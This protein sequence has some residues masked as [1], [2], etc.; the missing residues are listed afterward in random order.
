MVEAAFWGFVGG[1]SL[2][3]GALAGLKFSASQRVIGLIMAFGAGVL[4]SA[5]AFEPN[6]KAF[7]HGGAVVGLLTVLGFA[8][9]FLLS[10]VG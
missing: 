8:S 7:E 5:L 1:F 10:T 6:Q 3:L 9:A 4:I 2:L